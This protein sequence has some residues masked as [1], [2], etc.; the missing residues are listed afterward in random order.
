[1]I[2]LQHQLTIR[3]KYNCFSWLYWGQSDLRAIH[4][5]RVIWL[6]T[7]IVFEG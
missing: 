1:M 5:A 7:R 2:E 4:K 6:A 3:T